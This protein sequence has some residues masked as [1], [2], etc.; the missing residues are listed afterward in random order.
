MEVTGKTGVKKDRWGKWS[1]R[2]GEKKWNFGKREREKS[3]TE[4]EKEDRWVRRK[5]KKER[6]EARRKQQGLW[7]TCYRF[8]LWQ[9]LYNG[10]GRA[11]E[12]LNSQ[13]C[14][15][16]LSRFVI[17]IFCVCETE[18]LWERGFKSVCVCVCVQKR[19]SGC[20]SV[21]W[22]AR[23]ER[24]WERDWHKETIYVFDLSSVCKRE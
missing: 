22:W 8:S 2:L 15:G 1:Q 18:C 13:M 3:K 9:C 10:K 11:T 5:K 4:N 14:Q 17:S 24:K 21:H 6:G 7:A 20:A 19:L 12:R 23:E 16:E